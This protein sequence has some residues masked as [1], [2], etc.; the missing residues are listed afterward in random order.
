MVQVRKPLGIGKVIAEG[1]HAVANG[2]YLVAL[3]ELHGDRGKRQARIKRI[4]SYICY[5]F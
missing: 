5:A 1:E 3:A 4:G 2:F